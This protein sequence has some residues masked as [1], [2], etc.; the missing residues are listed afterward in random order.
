LAYVIIA[1]AIVATVAAWLGWRC[2]SL[3]KALAKAQA[4]QQELQKDRAIRQ[5]LQQVLDRREAEIRKLR[6][7]VDNYEKDYQEMESRASDLSMH[8]F[9][10]SGL[11]IIAEK[12]DGAK[13]MKMEQLEQQLD[14]LR[15]RVRQLNAQLK[16]TAAQAREREK[17]L[18]EDFSAREARLSEDFDARE[19]QLLGELK[20]QEE[21]INRLRT[22]NARRLARRKPQSDDGGLD[23]VTLEDIM[24]GNG[25]G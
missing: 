16:E 13:R 24:R 3:R 18:T 14:D 25:K 1:L 23:Q 20:A 22:L 11:R 5:N 15:R 2:Y 19:A 12:E 17:Q 9:Q 21:E 4:R 6:A 8:L 7:R 10:E